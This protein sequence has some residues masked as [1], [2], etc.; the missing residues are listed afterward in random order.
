MESCLTT[1]ERP[2]IAFF[3]ELGS[4]VNVR[5]TP[6]QNVRPQDVS[7]H[8]RRCPVKAQTSLKVICER[9]KDL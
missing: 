5:V 7:K 9:S 6:E 2:F 8:P 1:L 3:L 4:E